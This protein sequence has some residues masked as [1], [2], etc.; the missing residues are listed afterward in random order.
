MPLLPILRHPH[1]ALRRRCAEVAEIDDSLRRLAADMRETMQNASGVGLAAPQVGATAR[2]LVADVSEERD[3]PLVLVNPRII[4]RD[5][6]VLW[7]EGCLSVPGVL[8][9]VPRARAVSVAALDMR[10]EEIV[11]D[12]EELLSVCLQHEIDHLDGVLFFDHISLLKRKRLLARYSK[13]PPMPFPPP[14][15]PPAQE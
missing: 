3:N 13:L 15:P 2:L 8:A 1:A 9:L 14:R 5:G 4:R 10:G 11:I 6:E 12:A 7:E